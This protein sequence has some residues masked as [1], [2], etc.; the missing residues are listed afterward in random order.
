M[1]FIRDSS[2]SGALP[3]VRG[4]ILG[5]SFPNFKARRSPSRAAEFFKRAAYDAQN[6][7]FTSSTL[8]KKEPAKYDSRFSG[9]LLGVMD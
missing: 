6:D 4:D 7:R 9:L 5:D 3:K 8:Q 2:E 1:K